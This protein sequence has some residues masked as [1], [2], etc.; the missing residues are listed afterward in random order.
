MKIQV[1]REHAETMPRRIAI[2]KKQQLSQ[3]S[4]IA[5]STVPRPTLPDPTIPIGMDRVIAYRH[6]YL[7]A[8]YGPSVT[9]S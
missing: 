8:R 5:N 7:P 3:S 4:R 2:S 1:E 9:R 6:R